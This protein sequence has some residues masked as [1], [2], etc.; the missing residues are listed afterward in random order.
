MASDSLAAASSVQPFIDFIA[1]SPSAFHAAAEVKNRLSAAGFRLQQETEPWDSSP[2]GHMV[3]RGG[4]VLAWWIPENAGAHSAL[5]IVGSHTDSPGFMVRPQP[6][7][8]AAGWAQVGVE[9]Y[10]GPLLPSWFDRELEFAGELLLTDGSRTLVRT[11]P[12]ARIPHLAIHLTRSDDFKLNRHQH[13]QPVLSAGDPAMSIMDCV[14]EAAGVS[15]ADIRSFSLISAGTQ[16]GEVFGGRN[17][18]EFVSAG[19]MDNLS[20]VWASVTAL[21]A[22]V[23]RADASDDILVLAAFDHEE[24]GSQ[25]RYGA[26]GPLLED[27]LTRTLQALGLDSEHRYQ[28]FARSSC[29]SADAAHGIHPNYPEKHDPHDPPMLGAGPVVKVNANQR[30]ATS[31][32]SIGQWLSAC[33]QADI[34]VQY[35]ASRNDVPC[36]STIGPIS[37]TRLGIDTID[38]GVPMLSMHSARELI[39]SADQ[40][41]LARGLEAYWVGPHN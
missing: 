10:G 41:W 39:A 22:A 31:A 27:I 33:E 26:A 7:Q 23:T 13:L 20:S 15:R 19:R 29:I 35:F 14:A 8:R 1:A 17:G 28:V 3:V 24:V 38:L 34:P 30:Y 4:A 32:S 6:D 11:G 16:P 5:K 12:V 18:D 9:I 21:E 37:A 40:L 2:G 25:S 36:G